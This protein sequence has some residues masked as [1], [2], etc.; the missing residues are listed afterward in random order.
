MVA[1]ASIYPST[2]KLR[3][4]LLAGIFDLD[5]LNFEVKFD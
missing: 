2:L 1:Y 5:K 4:I 3:I